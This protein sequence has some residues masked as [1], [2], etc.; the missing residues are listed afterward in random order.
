[1][2]RGTAII[3]IMIAMTIMLM[4]FVAIADT[5]FGDQSF[6]IG[7]QTSAEA[8]NKAQDL[9]EKEQSLA[10]KDFNLVNNIASS[11]DDIYEKAVYV[12]LKSDFLTKEVKALI[13]WKDEHASTRLLELTT[14][15]ANFDTPVGGSTCD[16]TLSGD[17]THPTI[18][19]IT[20]D[21]AQII[22]DASGV[23]TLSDIDAYK[24]KLYVTAG[25]TSAVTSPT[26]FVLHSDDAS[27]TLLGKIDNEGPGGTVKAGLSAVRVAEDPASSPVKTYA[28]AANVSGSNYTTCTP[29]PDWPNYKRSCGQLDIID[30]TEPASWMLWN[31]TITN[32]MIASATPPYVKGAQ[33]QGNSLFY[34][35]GY[36]LFGLAATG[37]GNGP[38]FHIIDVH[39]QSLDA[40]FSSASHLVN[41]VGSYAVGHDVNAIALR[42][43]YAYLAV[44]NGGNELQVLSLESPSS[45][46]SVGG[47]SIPG[48]GNGKSIYLVGN[49]LYLGNTVPSAGNDLNILN[50]TDP[51]SSLSAIGGTDLSSSVNAVIVRDHL[52]FVLTNTDL[53]VYDIGDPESTD[54]VTIGSP[55]GTLALSATGS[56]TEPSMDCE[57]NRLYITTNDASGRGALYVVGPH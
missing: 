2:K 36:L 34:K 11:T 26:F 18:K 25:N 52:A 7:G 3:E 57:G 44:P 49:R 39:K 53:R 29:R 33:A 46:V 13:S 43:A 48:S 24:G 9:L 17:W 45:M 32:L 38:E 19:N 15:V 41:T 30:V 21:F 12:N 5:S 23:Y 8:L 28:Y 1:M 20:T 50:N 31:P 47:F 54:P 37:S 56:A 10:R 55:V 16:S 22:G 27:P 6:L 40:Y 51:A 14:L 42:G 4:V 35:N